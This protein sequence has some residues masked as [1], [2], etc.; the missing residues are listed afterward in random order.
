MHLL[1]SSAVKGQAAPLINGGCNFC[2]PYLWLWSKRRI[3]WGKW[4]HL[5][6]PM[7]AVISLVWY[8]I[9]N[10]GSEVDPDLKAKIL[11]FATSQK[12]FCPIWVVGTRWQKYELPLKD[13]SMTPTTNWGQKMALASRRP[14]YPVSYARWRL[15]G[16]NPA[17][18]GWSTAIRRGGHIHRSS[19]Y[20]LHCHQRHPSPHT[21]ILYLIYLPLIHDGPILAQP[22]PSPDPHRLFPIRSNPRRRFLAF[23][24]RA[25][26]E[27]SWMAM[28]QDWKRVSEEE[29]SLR[30]TKR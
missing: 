12:S 14:T 29:N 21:T 27:T 22:I 13:R 20:Q 9:L 3:K 24:L 10:K 26:Y 1:K 16:S 25:H 23:S 11:W 28:F 18:S 4:I 8:W 15:R 7:R 19:P 30:S 2:S 17:V 6:A 5:F